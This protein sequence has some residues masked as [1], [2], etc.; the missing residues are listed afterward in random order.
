MTHLQTYIEQDNFIRTAGNMVLTLIEV[1]SQLESDGAIINTLQ[2]KIKM[3]AS[4]NKFDPS[5]MQNLSSALLRT[6]QSNTRKTEYKKSFITL[7]GQINDVD[8]KADIQAE[9][10]KLA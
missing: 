4:L 2:S 9:I 1:N 6:E 7:K 10:D 8:I 3:A 5:D